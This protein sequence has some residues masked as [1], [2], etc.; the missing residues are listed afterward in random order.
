MSEIGIVL[1]AGEIPDGSV[2]IKRTGE[3]RYMLSRK[4]NIYGK[5]KPE[6]KYCSGILFLMSEEYINTVLSD[7]LLI[8]ITTEEDY[9]NYLGE[10]LA[11]R[12]SQ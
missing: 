1:S 12:D 7:T 9:F 4:I 10:L 11:E 8:W 2:V 5:S 6:I 3:K